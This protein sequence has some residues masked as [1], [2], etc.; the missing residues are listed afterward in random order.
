MGIHES[1]RVLHLTSVGQARHN[2]RVTVDLRCVMLRHPDP[3]HQRYLAAQN[4]L[5]YFGRMNSALRA[6]L[7]PFLKHVALALRPLTMAEDIELTFTSK[8]AKLI[9]LFQPTVIINDLAAVITRASAFIPEEEKISVSLVQQETHK[10]TLQIDISGVNLSNIGAITEG[11]R[12]PVTV[13]ST[14]GRTTRYRFEIE[15]FDTPLP[16]SA[17][18]HNVP[19]TNYVPDQYA[20]LR[21]RLRAHFN[22]SDTLSEA[23]LTSQPKEASFLEKVNQAILQNLGNSRFDANALSD[24]LNMSRTQL[25]RRL[26][27]LIRQSPGRYIRSIKLQRAKELFE[28]TDLRISEVAYRTG[29]ETAS[30]FTKVFTRQ[31]GVKPSLFCKRKPLNPGKID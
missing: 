4:N 8:A 30:H 25:Y 1:F 17:E 6:D 14:D 3:R 24:A 13:L 9:A 28:T 23:L 5:A 22:N 12:L 27:P 16:S 29:F 19:A 21:N 15:W 26:L 20:E 10:C 18:Q 31:Y 2:I 11:C 7:V